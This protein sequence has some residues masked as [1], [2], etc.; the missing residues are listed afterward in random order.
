MDAFD[1]IRLDQT[2]FALSDPTRRAIL[3]RLA[4]GEASVA[5]LAEPF[6]IS[7]PA[8]SRHLKV[9]EH[10]GLISRGRDAQRRPARLDPQTMVEAGA[11]I[12]HYRTI[13]ETTYQRLDTLLA[14]DVKAKGGDHA[15]VR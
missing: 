3:T 11:W 6:G 15:R 13:W 10:A 2:F 5:E 12:E 1:P 14:A 4:T 7:Q 9:L 8:I